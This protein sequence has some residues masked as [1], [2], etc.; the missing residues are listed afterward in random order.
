MRR[1]IFASVGGVGAAV[2]GTLCCLGAPL[3]L[4]LGIGS[5]AAAALGPLRPVFGALTVFFLAAG[6]YM[7]HR[8]RAGDRSRPPGPTDSVDG[9]ARR[10]ARLLLWAATGLALLLWA[11]PLFIGAVGGMDR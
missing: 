9:G 10:R 5:G 6:F 4:A 2:L 7:L 1:S 11:L 3:F 8:A